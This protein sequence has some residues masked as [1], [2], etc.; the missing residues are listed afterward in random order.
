MHSNTF[1]IQLIC[2]TPLLKWRIKNYMQQSLFSA[3][4]LA[5][6]QGCL[7]ILSLIKHILIPNHQGYSN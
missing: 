2:F 3:A 6:A 5:S 1:R 7:F 4:L